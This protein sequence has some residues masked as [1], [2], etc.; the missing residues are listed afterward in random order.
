MKAMKNQSAASSG[1]EAMKKT[2]KIRGNGGRQ[3]TVWFGM[4]PRL[5]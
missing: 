1:S 4:S 5:L 3:S 2:E